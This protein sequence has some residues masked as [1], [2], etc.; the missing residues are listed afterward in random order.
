MI[1][2]PIPM[3]GGALRVDILDPSIARIAAWAERSRD[4]TLVSPTGAL[5]TANTRLF[6]SLERRK[7]WHRSL[8][9][10]VCQRHDNDNFV[11]EPAIEPFNMIIS[12]PK[13]MAAMWNVQFFFRKPKQRP[14]DPDLKTKMEEITPQFFLRN[15]RRAQHETNLPYVPFRDEFWRDNEEY[16]TEFG[17]DQV[18]TYEPID[19]DLTPSW[20]TVDDNRNDLKAVLYDLD[21]FEKHGAWREG[22]KPSARPRSIHSYEQIR[23]KGRFAK[24]DEL[25]K[26]FNHGRDRKY[27]RLP[28]YMLH[29]YRHR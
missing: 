20:V 25:L 18:L 12:S 15:L 5:A 7:T 16:A 9:M 24:P 26:E 2:D 28:P 3:A 19:M 4:A 17:A 23:E 11:P 22:F 6:E 14:P 13:K 10:Q 8:G 27:R 1:K 21:W 29:I